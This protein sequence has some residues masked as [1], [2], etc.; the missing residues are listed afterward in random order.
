MIRS[1]LARLRGTKDLLEKV[2]LA[3]IEARAAGLHEDNPDVLY[4]ILAEQ[5]STRARL[6]WFLGVASIM[7]AIGLYHVLTAGA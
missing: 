2:R 3:K 5:R 4:L 7:V 6:E 1:L